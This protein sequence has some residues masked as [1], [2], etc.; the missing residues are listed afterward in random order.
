MEIKESNIYLQL[1]S[2]ARAVGRNLTE[3]CKILNIS[4]PY[5][6]LWKSKE[7]KAL[8]AIRKIKAEIAKTDVRTYS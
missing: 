2:E 4:R 1:D 8:D 6:H 7:P 3:I 5:L